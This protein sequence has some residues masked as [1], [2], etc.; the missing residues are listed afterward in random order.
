M[1]FFG[2]KFLLCWALPHY[3]LAGSPPSKELRAGQRPEAFRALVVALVTCWDTQKQMPCLLQEG[4]SQHWSGLCKECT[5]EGMQGKAS[6]CMDDP[7]TRGGLQVPHCC[8]TGF[9]SLVLLAELCWAPVCCLHSQHLPAAR[10][11]HPRLFPPKILGV[12]SQSGFSWM[13]QHCRAPEL[14]PPH[15]TRFKTKLRPQSRRCEPKA[16]CSDL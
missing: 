15:P 2:C 9:A 4:L 14:H 1:G 10:H 7:W 8:S 16:T 12:P 6:L 5:D 3:V 11:P 13:C